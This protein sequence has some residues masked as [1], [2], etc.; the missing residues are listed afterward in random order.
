MKGLAGLCDFRSSFSPCGRGRSQDKCL[1]QSGTAHSMCCFFLL[2]LFLSPSLEQGPYTCSKEPRSKEAQS[3]QG[4]L[5]PSWLVFS[6][7]WLT[8]L[9]LNSC[10]NADKS[11]KYQISCYADQLKGRWLRLFAC[12]IF[13]CSLCRPGIFLAVCDLNLASGV[14]GPQLRPFRRKIKKDW[15]KW[16]K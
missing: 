5:M 15:Y 2:F 12:S 7:I 10:K 9:A 14:V 13:K 11:V 16:G 6:F 4:S 8:Q 3:R 1:A